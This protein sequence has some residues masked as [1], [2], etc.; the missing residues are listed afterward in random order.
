MSNYFHQLVDVNN[1][2]RASAHIWIL[3]RYNI[4]VLARRSFIM[5]VPP[6]LLVLFLTDIANSELAVLSLKD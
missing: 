2:V 1:L 6:G 3:R 4:A 5:P